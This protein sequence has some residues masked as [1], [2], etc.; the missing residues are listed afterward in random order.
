MYSKKKLIN[1]DGK[2]EE[3][4]QLMQNIKLL[5]LALHKARK[6]FFLLKQG[7][8]YGFIETIVFQNLKAFYNPLCDFSLFF[9]FMIYSQFKTLFFKLFIFFCMIILT[10]YKYLNK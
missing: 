1:K 6:Q 9:I 5:K 10:I 2:K 4:F 3:N 7:C 8:T